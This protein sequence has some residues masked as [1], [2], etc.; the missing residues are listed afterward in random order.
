MPPIPRIGSLTA[1]RTCQTIRQAL[2]D[3]MAKQPCYQL[4][5]KRQTPCPNC[6]VQ[7]LSGEGS[8]YIQCEIDNWNSGAKICSRACNLFWDDTN[9]RPLALVIQEPF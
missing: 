5:H 9:G 1:F 6:P 7:K 8:E 4:F 3:G 2:P